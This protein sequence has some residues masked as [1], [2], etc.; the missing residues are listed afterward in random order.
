MATVKSRCLILGFL[1]SVTG[2]FVAT[3]LLLPNAAAADQRPKEKPRICQSA[4]ER[5]KSTKVMEASDEEMVLFSRLLEAGIAMEAGE[6][7]EVVESEPTRMLR[8]TALLALRYCDLRQAKEELEALLDV[9]PP[10]PVHET[11]VKTLL[12]WKSSKARAIVARILEDPATGPAARL[13]WYPE[14][15]RSGGD[16]DLAFVRSMATS[17]EEGLRHRAVAVE[18]SLLG[19]PESSELATGLLRDHLRDS[20]KSVRR[21][22]LNAIVT[23][24]L[25]D[26][27]GDVCGLI[28]EAKLLVV[29]R[30]EKERAEQWVEVFRRTGRCVVSPV[31]R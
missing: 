31:E 4:E 29:E 8:L 2:H 18:A 16:C 25:E 28:S 30:D 19:R 12:R 22:A 20:S 24:A 1:A 5:K 7:L 10:G 11:L 23:V 26:P 9:E 15:I 21:E 14:F 27:H 17:A 3:A 6:L 13:D